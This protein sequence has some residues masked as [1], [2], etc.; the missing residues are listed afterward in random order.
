MGQYTNIGRYP[1][2][3]AECSIAIDPGETVELSQDVIDIV[4]KKGWLPFLKAKENVV[5]EKK[6]SKK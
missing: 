4:A 6:E 5:V 3:I 2:C 1:L